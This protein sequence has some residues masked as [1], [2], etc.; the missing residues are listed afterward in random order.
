LEAIAVQV[1]ARSLYVE[2]IE[3]EVGSSVPR[4]GWLLSAEWADRPEKRWVLCMTERSEFA[5]EDRQEH[6]GII[7]FDD[8]H[9]HA[10]S[11][12]CFQRI[13]G[14]LPSQIDV[15]RMSGYLDCVHG[16][17]LKIRRKA[18]SACSL[19]ATQQQRVAG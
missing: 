12:E 10:R 9:A 17:P 19:C 4:T 13:A 11:F 6:L 7:A 2:T 8:P 14:L 1:D 15:T 18:A 3:S 5:P 16:A